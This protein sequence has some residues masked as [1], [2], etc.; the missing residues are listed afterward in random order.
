MHDIWNPWH[1]CKK[2]SEGCANCYMY[3][4]DKHRG[5][6]GG[7]I[8]RA[9]N[10]FYYPLQK[11]RA[12]NYKIKSGELIRICMTS[13]FFLEEADAWRAEAWQ[14]IR[15]RSD[16]KFFILTKRP[17]RVKEHLPANWGDGWEN[18]FFNVT[19]E[20]QRR[21]DER[22]PILLELPFKHKGVMCAPFIGE[23]HMEKY[24]AA[25]Q[26]EQVICG[27]ENY[28]GARPCNYDWV[29]SLR[30]QCEKRNVSFAFLET[31]SVFVKDGRTYHIPNKAVQS[32]MAYKSGIHYKGKP[33]VF[34]LTDI[35]GQ[36]IPEREWYEPHYREN[37]LEC[38]GRQTCNG[39]GDCGKCTGDI[40]TAAQMK[41]MEQELRKKQRSSELSLCRNHRDRD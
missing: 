26:I 34:H 15:A 4:L 33:M 13:D 30:M 27:G 7:D 31:G 9:K 10:G 17:Q 18:V 36:E 16:V 20:N 19:C 21:A 6:F 12:G 14:I 1:G 37:C 29:K 3:Y 11:D 40:I 24:L 28:G 8:F 23:V 41:K 22:L 32:K 35:Y 2:I 5:K 25:G 38:G 39:C